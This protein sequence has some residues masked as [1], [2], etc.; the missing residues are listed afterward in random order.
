MEVMEFGL[1]ILAG[2]T[3]KHVNDCLLQSPYRLPSQLARWIILGGT[4]G[5]RAPQWLQNGE[6][7]TVLTLGP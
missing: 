3:V 6:D 7:P 5:L 1:E 4:P 2:S